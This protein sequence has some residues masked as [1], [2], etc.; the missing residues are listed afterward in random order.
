VHMR[1]EYPGQIITSEQDDW[2][3]ETAVRKTF[4]NAKNATKKKFKGDSP[5][6][7]PYE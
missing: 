4:N 5:R 7:K 2:D 1:L 3:I 6:E